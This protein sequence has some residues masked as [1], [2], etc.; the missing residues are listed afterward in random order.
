MKGE[1]PLFAL[2]WRE[3]EM[4]VGESFRRRGYQVQETGGEGPQA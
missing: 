4:V 3:F 1:D 2:T